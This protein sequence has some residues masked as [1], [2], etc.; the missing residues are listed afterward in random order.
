MPIDGSHG[1]SAGLGIAAWELIKAVMTSVLKRRTDQGEAKRKVLREDVAAAITAVNVCLGSA[2]ENFTSVSNSARKSELSSAIR[3]GVLDVAHR[4]QSVNVGLS[5][6]GA[7]CLS[8][9]YMIAFRKALTMIL[10]DSSQLVLDADN[11]AITAMYRASHNL[12]MA[13]TKTKYIAT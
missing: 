7:E 1:I 12:Q 8:S 9:G 6:I 4:F 3:H 11:P 2:I 13:L 5:E 10:D